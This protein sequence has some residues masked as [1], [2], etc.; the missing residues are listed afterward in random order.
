MNL[1]L[2]SQDANDRY[3]TYDSA[4]VCC[5]TEE[6]ARMIHPAGDQWHGDGIATE[7]AWDGKERNYGSWCDAEY[8][9]VELIGVAAPHIKR[10]VV[11]AS[12]N[13]G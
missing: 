3:D 13:A 9:K 6:E 10:G 11:I 8:V 2:I 5:G 1:Y 7:E 12:F 4:V